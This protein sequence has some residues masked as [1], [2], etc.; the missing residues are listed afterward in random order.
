MSRSSAR[1]WSKPAAAAS[2]RRPASTQRATISSRASR[3]ASRRV[4]VVGLA[5][6]EGGRQLGRGVPHGLSEGGDRVGPEQPL[7]EA[8]FLPAGAQ[9]V[10]GGDEGPARLAVEFGGGGPSDGNQAGGS[11]LGLARRLRRA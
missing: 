1:S 6:L 2:S 10:V 8:E 11:R 5:Q 7:H 4:V 3:Q 9:A